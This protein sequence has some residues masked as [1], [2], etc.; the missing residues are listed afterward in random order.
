MQRISPLLPIKWQQPTIDGGWEDSP[1]WSFGSVA[2]PVRTAYESGYA[3]RKSKT[4]NGNFNALINLF[5]GMNVNMQY[6]YNYWTRD[7][8]NWHPTMPRY[9]ANGT[10]HPSNENVRNNI[11]VN[12][13]SILT[14]TLNS[15]L[16]YEKR[17]GK[18]GFKFL[19]GYSQE[20][21]FMPSLSARREN[22]LLEGIEEINA[23][24][25]NITNSGTASQ[26][27]LR[28]YFGRL[29]YDFSEK[30][31]FEANVRYDG[32]SRFSS[33]NNN[34]WGLFPSFSAGW[35]FSEEEFLEFSKPLLS[36][37]KIRLSWGEL[38]NQTLGSEYYPYLVEIE[39]QDKSYPIGGVNNVGFKQNKLANQVIKWE[40]IRML[41]AGVD[42]S[43]FDNRL[44]LTFDWFKKEN[45][46]A[47][48]KPIYPAI[49]GIADP[50]NLPYENIGAIE[51]KGWEVNIEWRDQIG[52]MRYGFIA[53]LS[54]AKNKIT[55]L[56]KSAPS[57][58]NNIR[59]EGDPINA[60]Y[61]FLT[62][63]LLQIDDFESYDEGTGKYINP[64]VATI[65]AYT[66]IVQPGDVKYLDI[67]GPD[68]QPDNKIDDYDKTV[69][70]DPYPRY[71]YSF[72]GY[73]VWKNIDFQFYLQGVAKVNGY[74]TEEARHCFVN[75][76]SVP[77]TAHLDRWTPDNTDATYPRMYYN[78][79]HNIVFSDYWLEDASY[80]RLKNIQLGYSIPTSILR[81]I[82]LNRARI[83]GTAENL[84][85]ITDY[86]GGF[87][88]E[89]RETA[90]DN[91]PQVKTFSLGVQ[92]EF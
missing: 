26:W 68:G 85:T 70:G 13:E 66:S 52:N 80:L 5:K 60:Y 86:F 47:L 41:N 73:L 10:P 72:K 7:T 90:G 6:A 89:V 74:L 20:W 16:N 81:R 21:A 8:K 58:G 78:P 37:G 42:L 67:S 49:V 44:N 64:K 35:R 61:G 24:T 40:T 23:G 33:I 54:D 17:F 25:E 92:I 62:D 38:G 22:I 91:Y 31:L 88:P 48:L 39:R 50:N 4:F 71:S 36:M 15:T 12:N 83:Y 32:T 59:R 65:N 18:H 3:D 56:G 53:N 51:N 43:F 57:L 11:S 76:Y 46:N 29:N 87:D 28:S 30:Y 2:N 34:R 84:L 69:F 75:D 45:I 27:A 63:G 14:Q 79:A 19:A 9:Y 1:Y 77:K 55:K 82:K